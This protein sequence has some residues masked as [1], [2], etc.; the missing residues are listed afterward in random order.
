MPV[1]K[2]DDL[3]ICDNWRGISL[4]DVM[5]KLFARV[6]NDRLQTVAEDSVADSQCGFRAGR[7]CVDMV[8]CVHQLSTTSLPSITISNEANQINAFIY[9][10]LRHCPSTVKCNCYRSMVRP[11]LEYAS[12]VWDPHTLNNINRIEAVQRRAARFCLMSFQVTLVL[13]AC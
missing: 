8:F 1:P 6:I 12:S 5:G 4:L 13:L 10:N 7:G 3:S 11:V 9:R 2:R